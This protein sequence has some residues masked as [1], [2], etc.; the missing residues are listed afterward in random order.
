M[1]LLLRHRNGGRMEIYKRL[2]FSNRNVVR[3]E[4]AVASSSLYI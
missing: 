2:K 4:K 3:E 1:V